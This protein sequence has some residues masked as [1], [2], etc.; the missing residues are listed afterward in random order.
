[1]ANSQAGDAE[2]QAEPLPRQHPLA[3]P[4]IGQRR[5]QHR[6]QADH[7]RDQ[8]GGQPVLDRSEH[9]AEIAAVHQGA[10]HGAVEYTGAVRPFRPGE[11]DDDGEQQHDR[12]HAQRQECHRLRI[13]Q[14]EFGADESGRPQHDKDGGR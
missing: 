5:R 7:E 6:L 9:A 10:G 8:A 13:G 4:A 14:A 1:M 11:H 12:D 2:Q 3:E